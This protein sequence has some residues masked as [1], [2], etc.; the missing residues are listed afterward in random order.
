MIQREFYV[1]SIH[2]ELV[3]MAT[4]KYSS[5]SYNKNP[6]KYGENTLFDLSGNQEDFDKL[7][8]DVF[9]ISIGLG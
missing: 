7:D 3:I 6:Q 9:R 1:E 4:L 2:S 8:K 5:I